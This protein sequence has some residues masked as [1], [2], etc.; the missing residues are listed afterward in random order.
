[1]SCIN[2]DISVLESSIGY[3]FKDRGLLVTALSHS[4]YVNEVKAQKLYSYERLEFLGD[5]VLELIS[6][7]YL[8]NRF[9]DMKEGELSK[10]RASLVCEKTLAS[11]ADRIGL[12]NFILLGKGEFLQKGY[13]KP[14]VLCDCVES[15]LGAIYIDGGLQS[16]KDYVFRFILT[17]EDGLYTDCKSRV[18]EMIQAELSAK[19]EYI[20]V[21]E[22]GPDHNREY[23]MALMV[24]GREIARGIGTSKKDAEQSAAAKAIDVWEQ[25]KDTCI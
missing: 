14:S 1:M 9:P 13:L 23:T 2:S 7:E 18:Q 16:C 6:S 11:C 17:G 20:L 10:R 25:R 4:S 22:T 5:A 19:P 12:G 24:E 3:E 15:V 21:S 8:F